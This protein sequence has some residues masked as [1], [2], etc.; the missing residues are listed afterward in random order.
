MPI[1]PEVVDIAQ[2][3]YEHAQTA[4]NG[5]A[6]ME[7]AIRAADEARGYPER[8][9]KRAVGLIRRLMVSSL[10]TRSP[11]EHERARAEALDF[12][13]ESQ[14]SRLDHDTEENA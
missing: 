7:V 6:P 8:K 4:L 9:L 11:E 13:S 10:P 5:P 14:D 1:A 2:A 12:L 3:A